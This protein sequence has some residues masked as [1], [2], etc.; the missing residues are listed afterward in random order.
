MNIL[1]ESSLKNSN[2][3]VNSNMYLLTLNKQSFNEN[4]KWFHVSDSN[5]TQI[6]SNVLKK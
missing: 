6:S 2:S 3:D 5:A 1:Y 4:G